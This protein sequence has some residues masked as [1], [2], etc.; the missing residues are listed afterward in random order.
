MIEHRVQI[1]FKIS[2]ELNMSHSFTH[3]I[4]DAADAHEA[5]RNDADLV[6]FYNQGYAKR[7][8]E[9]AQEGLLE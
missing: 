6:L 1:N 5:G 8:A 9:Q 2:G 3:L 7:C 4:E